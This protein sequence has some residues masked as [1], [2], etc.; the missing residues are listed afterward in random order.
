MAKFKAGN[1]PADH[2]VSEVVEYLKSDDATPDEY[3]R[4]MTAERDRSG[5]G[6]LGILNL[7]GAESATDDQMVTPSGEP[8]AGPNEAATGQESPADQAKT[9]ADPQA[10]GDAGVT[11]EQYPDE[12]PASLGPDMPQSEAEADAHAQTL[13]TQAAATQTPEQ[14]R[15]LAAERMQEWKQNNTR[16]SDDA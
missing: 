16:T 7:S 3:D 5:G 9:S 14:A 13:A 2:T 10:S 15:A 6:R 11:A 4:V 1:D 8:A 12:A